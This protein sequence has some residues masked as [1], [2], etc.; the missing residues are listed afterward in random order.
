MEI[1][2]ATYPGILD[3]ERL[4]TSTIAGA[5]LVVAGVMLG[6]LG[7]RSTAD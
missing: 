2:T 6:A 4:E 7:S 1:F 3:P 5:L